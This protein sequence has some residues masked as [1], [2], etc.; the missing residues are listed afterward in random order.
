MAPP[1]SSGQPKPDSVSR[2]PEMIEP[3][4][5]ANVLGTDVTLAAAGRSSGLT[6]A[7]TYDARV[8]TSICDNALRAINKPTAIVRFG[9]NGISIRNTFDGRWVKT[10]VLIRPNRSAI[11][12]AIRYETAEQMPLQNRIAAVVVTETWKV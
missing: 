8:G 9:A 6:T 10:I 3:V 4:A 7:I 1:I 12:T 2:Y 11:G 5:Q